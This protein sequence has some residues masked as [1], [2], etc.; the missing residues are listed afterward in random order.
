MKY[1][2]MAMLAAAA[3]AGL[4]I[5]QTGNPHPLPPELQCSIECQR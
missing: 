4:V 2:R 5:Y 1:G 3:A